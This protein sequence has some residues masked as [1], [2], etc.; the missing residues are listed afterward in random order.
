MEFRELL[1][2]RRMVRHYD[3]EPIP[4]E[5]L[6]RIVSTVRR[7]P[8]GGFSQGQRLLV[9]DDPELLAQIAQVG[10][11]A[12][13]GT[14]PWF[15]SAPVQILV[16]TREDDYHDRYRKEDKLQDGDEIEWP[17]PFWYVDAGAALMLVLLAVIDEGLAAA[18]YG[19]FGEEEQRLRELLAIPDDFRVV[20]GVTL[21][22]PLPDPEW[23]KLTSRATQRRRPLDE[24]VHWNRWSS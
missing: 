7:A 20:A 6:E 2:R 9:V 21:G 4:R 12:P 8:S 11:G 15:E 13:E 14:E 3:G 17:V 22:R 23:S 19:V 24:L 1:K 16:M 10:E 5:T 18:V